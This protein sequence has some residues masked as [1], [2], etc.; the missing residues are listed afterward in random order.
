MWIS[1]AFSLYSCAKTSIHRG[2]QH[3]PQREF[4]SRIGTKSRVLDCKTRM[5]VPSE[6]GPPTCA[7]F[8]HVGV[9]K[10]L[11]EGSVPALLFTKKVQYVYVR[12]P[13]LLLW[14]LPGRFTYG[15][16]LP[17]QCTFRARNLNNP[18]SCLTLSESYSCEKPKGKLNEITLWQKN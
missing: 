14:V 16:F 11:S 1:P 10:I 7:E 6:P 13:P 5:L 2:P 15:P 4:H 9:G 17:H 3:A 12:A 18:P 8:A